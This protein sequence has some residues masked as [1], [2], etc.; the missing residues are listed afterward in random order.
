MY[1][2]SSHFDSIGYLIEWRGCLLNGSLNTANDYCKNEA[3]SLIA[4]RWNNYLAGNWRTFIINQNYMP[5]CLEQLALLL[6]KRRIMKCVKRFYFEP[7]PFCF[8]SLWE[9]L[10]VST[11]RI[12]FILMKYKKEKKLNMACKKKQQ[13]QITLSEK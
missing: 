3:L 12:L 5:L 6:K 4:T 8:F 9:R 2:T 10:Y 13:Q 11:S 7:L 1:L